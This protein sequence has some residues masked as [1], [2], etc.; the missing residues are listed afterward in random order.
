M[1][2]VDKIFNQHASTTNCFSKRI[3]LRPSLAPALKDCGL[4][5]SE[6]EIELVF[7]QADLN[8]DQGL[9][10]DEFRT[11]VKF[12]TKLQQWADTLP[13]SQLLAHCLAAKSRNKQDPVKDIAGLSATDLA[14][15]IDLFCRCVRRIL[16]ERVT[17]LEKCFE[18]MGRLGVQRPTDVPHAT[19]FVDQMVAMIGELVARDSA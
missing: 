11:A 13:L 19:E 4:E 2:S 14:D 9:D 8:D 6:E 7:K 15:T 3:L 10:L 18:A 16:A 17:E 12:P 5:L 1:A